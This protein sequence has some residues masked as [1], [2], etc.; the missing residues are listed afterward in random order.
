MQGEIDCLYRTEFNPGVRL[1]SSLWLAF[2]LLLGVSATPFLF[3]D[4][5]TQQQ[6]LL[7]IL[8]NVVAAFIVLPG[9]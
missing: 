2:A 7:G 5:S 9:F 1:S 3:G 8:G 6:F 4:A